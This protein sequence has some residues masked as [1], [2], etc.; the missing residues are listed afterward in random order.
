MMIL[1]HMCS[2]LKSTWVAEGKST[3]ARRSWVGTAGNIVVLRMFWVCP[4]N[5]SERSPLG[6]VRIGVTG[7]WIKRKQWRL[8]D[9]CCWTA[10]MAQ[11][12][13]TDN[14]KT[15]PWSFIVLLARGQSVLWSV[16]VGRRRWWEM[17]WNGMWMDGDAYLCILTNY[18][19]QRFFGHETVQCLGR[20]QGNRFFF[21]VFWK[22][23]VWKLS[24]IVVLTTV[25]SLSLIF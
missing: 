22:Y 19:E 9:V 13:D 7:N 21:F 6:R 17:P 23:N 12:T 20:L 1:F 14:A 3:W 24:V 4:K 5:G 2:T 16:D 11:Q 15:E 25:L 8:L 10:T 18:E